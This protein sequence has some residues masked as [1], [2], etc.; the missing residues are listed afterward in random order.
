MSAPDPAPQ[1][2]TVVCPGS[3]DPITHGHLDIIG[4]AA[5]LFDT[6]VVAVGVNAGKAG[7]LFDVDERV[8]MAQQACRAWPGVEVDRFSG[9]LVDYCRERGATAVVKGLRNAR[10]WEYEVA[11]AHMNVEL[12]GLE[13]VFLPSAARW[14]SV[15]STLV[16]EV[17]RLGG[18]PSAF[19]PDAVATATLARARDRG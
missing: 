12:T 14:G 6:V 2:R 5:A 11:M 8:A 17:A 1:H 10:D 18:D 4:R 9:L 13:T 3:F 19:L 15:S 7:A 16:R